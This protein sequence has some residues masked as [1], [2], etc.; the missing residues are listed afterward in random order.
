MSNLTQHV[1]RPL[2]YVYVVVYLIA[3]AMFGRKETPCD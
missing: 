1:P 2:L 3:G